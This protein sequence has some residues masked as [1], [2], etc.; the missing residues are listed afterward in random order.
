MLELQIFNKNKGKFVKVNVW[1]YSNIRLFFF[2]IFLFGIK[3]FNV[4]KCFYVVGRIDFLIYF[5]FQVFMSLVN[6]WQILIYLSGIFLYE[7]YYIIEIV[8]LS[9]C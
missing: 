5:D 3:D 6:L 4:F 2:V 7:R 8:L 1:V 9:G